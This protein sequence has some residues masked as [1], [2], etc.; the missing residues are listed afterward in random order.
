[1][2]RLIESLAP[3]YPEDIEKIR[4]LTPFLMRFSD[5]EIEKLWEDYSDSMCAGWLTVDKE[6]IIM[7]HNWLEG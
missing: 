1:M 7:F 5:I 4:N 6:Q 3:R 2:N